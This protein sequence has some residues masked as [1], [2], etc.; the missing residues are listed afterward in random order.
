M[1]SIVSWEYYSSLH[2][3]VSSTEFAAIETLAEKEVRQVIGPIK[4][5]TIT[6]STFGYDVLIDCICNVIDR[7]VDDNELL[8]REGIA[9]VSN[10]GYTENYGSGSDALALGFRRQDSIKSWLSGT[11]LVGAY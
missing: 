1:S 10:D 9:S 4:W 5:S 6:E 7:M 8:A 3:K 11:G 2:S